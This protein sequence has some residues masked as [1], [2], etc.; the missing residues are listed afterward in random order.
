MLKEMI[1]DNVVNFCYYKDGDLWYSLKH[2][3]GKVFM[4]P[5]PVSDV[6]TATMMHQ[7]KAILFMRWIRKQLKELELNH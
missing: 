4:F 6:G 1:K 2:D 3:N 5:V 7:D